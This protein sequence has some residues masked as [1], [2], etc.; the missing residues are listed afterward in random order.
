MSGSLT[1]EMKNL[2]HRKRKSSA[3]NVSV[4]HYPSD[5]GGL[6]N[7]KS[8]PTM[9]PQARILLPSCGFN[10]WGS[11]ISEQSRHQMLIAILMEIK[12]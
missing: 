10:V 6:E 1:Q 12:E 2:R 4:G 8:K 7:L 3:D 9:H 11:K 5:Q